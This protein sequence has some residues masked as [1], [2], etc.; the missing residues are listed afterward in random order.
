MNIQLLKFY[1]IVFSNINMVSKLTNM[2]IIFLLLQLHT[3]TASP[4]KSLPL[5]WWWWYY[6]KVAEFIYECEK[7]R[8]FLNEFPSVCLINVL[9][10]FLKK[11][12]VCQALNYLSRHCVSSTSN[13]ST[14]TISV[15]HSITIASVTDLVPLLF[16]LFQ[17]SPLIYKCDTNAIL[18]KNLSTA[19]DCDMTRIIFTI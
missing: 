11:I 3:L 15:T 2:G 7:E 17:N 13:W 16:V 1:F 14:E 18:K 5:R 12:S 6:D 8:I 19:S 10:F 4:P 9:S